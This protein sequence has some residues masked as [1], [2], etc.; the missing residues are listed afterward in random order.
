MIIGIFDSN[1]EIFNAFERYFKYGKDSSISFEKIEKE[2]LENITKKLTHKFI[3]AVSDNLFTENQNGKPKK[4]LFVEIIEY[5]RYKRF[6]EIPVLF[7]TSED[8]EYLYI[9][10]R[11]GMEDQGLECASCGRG[12]IHL[13]MPFDIKALVKKIEYGFQLSRTKPQHDNLIYLLHCQTKSIIP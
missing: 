3:I 10:S 7:I 1:G 2:F 6:F 4:G 12:N 5:V 13:K 11:S 8:I 9:L